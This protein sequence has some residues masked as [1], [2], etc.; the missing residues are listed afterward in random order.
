M[1]LA[2]PLFVA[3]SWKEM[4]MVLAWSVVMSDVHQGL[5]APT[6]TFQFLLERIVGITATMRIAR[7]NL[8]KQF[9]STDLQKM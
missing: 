3:L 8:S 5:G 6:T 1:Y 9:R 4:R 2:K 7:D